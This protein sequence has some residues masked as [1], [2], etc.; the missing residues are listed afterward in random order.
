MGG[1]DQSERLVA[2]NRNR[3][4][5]S[6]GAR[7]FI[8]PCLLTRA[9]AAPAGLDWA[10]EFKHD[11]YRFMVRCDGDDV[12]AFTRNGHDWT[13]RVPSIA[14]AAASMN[15]ASAT[16]DGECVILRS[17]G[18]S[19]F[20][21]LRSALSSGRA[22]GAILFAFDLLELDGADL[23]SRPWYERRT[24]LERVLRGLSQAIRLSEHL[25]APGPWF[26]VKRA[27][28]GATASCRSG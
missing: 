24:A 1:R 13:E 4:S 9:D 18:L 16:I 10:H 7:R 12:R 2:I 14:T 21:A 22:P 17:D 28:S 5:R 3:W 8:E 20:D 15:V 25:G 27:G 6:P 23:R 11:G 26:S 19:D